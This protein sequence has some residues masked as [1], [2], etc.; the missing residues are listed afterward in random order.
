MREISLVCV[1][2]FFSDVQ[3]SYW[4]GATDFVEEG[5]WVWHDGTPVQMG[6]PFWGPVSKYFSL[7]LIYNVTS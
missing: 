3:G 5:T 7:D 6:A 4:I 2:I 1:I